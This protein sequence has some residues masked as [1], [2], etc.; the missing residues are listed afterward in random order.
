MGRGANL[1]EAKERPE[2]YCQQ[3]RE[4]TMIEGVRSAVNTV[5]AAESVPTLL[6]QH[7]IKFYAPHTT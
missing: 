2:P 4:F 5:Q 7:K 6:I 1:S 3:E